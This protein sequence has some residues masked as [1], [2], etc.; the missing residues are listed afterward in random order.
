[1]KSSVSSSAGKKTPIAIPVA[2]RA[3]RGSISAPSANSDVMISESTSMPTL[4]QSSLKQN[5]LGVQGFELKLSMGAKD[6]S[7][8]VIKRVDAL[9]MPPPVFEPSWTKRMQVL[10]QDIESGRKDVLDTIPTWR[11]DQIES[12]VYIDMPHPT[13]LQTPLTLALEKKRPD[14][15]MALLLLGADPVA[16]D[17]KGMRPCA[18]ATPLE[19]RFLRFFALLSIASTSSG[20]PEAHQE[21]LTLVNSVEPKSGKTMLGWAIEMRNDALVERLMAHQTD[22]FKDDAEGKAPLD[23]ATR[24]G[25][26]S[27]IQTLLTVWSALPK[28]GL[29]CVYLRSAICEAVV[30]DRPMVVAECLSV[31]RTCYREESALHAGAGRHREDAHHFFLRGLQPADLD[32]REAMRSTTNDYVLNEQEC[33]LLGLP[34]IEALAIKLDRNKVSEVI[35]AH[36][37]PRY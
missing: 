16:Q 31:F 3:Y 19:A 26:L 2:D 33:V 23:F 1:M 29:H 5:P 24:C 10:F 9:S 6:A 37:K 36:T 21:I 4:K 25:T 8:P 34:V 13:S 27:L 22:L 32:V 17:G 35:A 7:E 15:A 20:V 28:S 18:C 14:I 12:G 30:A 11:D